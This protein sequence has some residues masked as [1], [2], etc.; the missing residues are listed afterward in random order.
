MENQEVKVE[1]E[2][3]EIL[4]FF[5]IV[6]LNET[7]ASSITRFLRDDGFFINEHT[8]IRWQKKAMKNAKNSISHS[9][10]TKIVVSRSL[11]FTYSSPPAR[12]KLILQY[13]VR[14]LILLAHA[15]VCVTFY[16]FDR[17]NCFFTAKQEN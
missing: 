16:V 6:L 10:I 7:S 4:F 1:W 11:L 17:E 2:E 3:I 9:T 14:A 13:S 8:H 15:G 5:F 12:I